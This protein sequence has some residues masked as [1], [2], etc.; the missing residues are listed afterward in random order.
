VQLAFAL[1]QVPQL[2]GLDPVCQ[3]THRLEQ[4]SFNG[5]VPGLGMDGRTMELR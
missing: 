5:I 1:F 3:L 4:R 2:M